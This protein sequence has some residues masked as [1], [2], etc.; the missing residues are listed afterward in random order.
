M[1]PL[2]SDDAHA[3]GERGSAVRV[4]RRR[5]FR[6]SGASGRAL[7][8]T[9]VI[10]LTV[11]VDLELANSRIRIHGKHRADPEWI[12][13][14]PATERALTQW[15]SMRGSAPGP[16]FTR[17][18]RHAPIARQRAGDP[19]PLT[20]EALRQL[21]R[22]LGK[23]VN[24]AARPHGLRHAAITE[25][26]AATHGDLRAVQRYARLKSAT[27]IT[28]YDDERADLGGAVARTVAP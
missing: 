15:L 17:L 25:A 14:P 3:S 22:D 16:L 10:R 6:S 19:G 18:D 11:P 21:V 4:A 28:V 13:I 1:D 27:A 8:R 5:T 7:R 12:S 23:R 2:W 26:L 9:E 20:G 24:V